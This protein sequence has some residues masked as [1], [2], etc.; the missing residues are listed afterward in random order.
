M[1][2]GSPALTQAQETRAVEDLHGFRIATKVLRYRTELLY[3]I[4]GKQMKAQLK[5][6]ADLQEALGVWHDRQVLHQAVAEAVARAEILLSELPTGTHTPG[7][8]GIGSHARQ[9]DDVEK[10]Y[11]L[12]TEHPE[13]K[14]LE[15]WER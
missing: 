15:S 9:A 10:I 14:Q 11:R 12:A 1:P 4:G 3:D 5:W 2:N 13:H 7:G 8:T 6:L